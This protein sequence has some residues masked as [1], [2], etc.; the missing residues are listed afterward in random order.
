MKVILVNDMHKLGVAGE[1]VKV[2]PGYARNFLLPRGMAL[3]ATAGNLAKAEGLRHKAEEDRQAKL[4][5]LRELAG[6][7]S[8]IE[9]IFK[10]KADENGHLFGS[11]SEIDVVQALAEKG[12]EVHKAMVEMEKHLKDLGGVEV[13][14]HLTGDIAA[15]LKVVVENEE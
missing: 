14:I 13:K 11:V 8:A 4:R 5:I 7:I 3:V 1:V 2:A 10:R 15:T 12:I 9:I 6:K